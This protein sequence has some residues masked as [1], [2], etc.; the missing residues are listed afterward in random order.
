MPADAAALFPQSQPLPTPLAVPFHV[1]RRER[2]ACY[3]YTSR[4]PV[5]VSAVAEDSRGYSNCGRLHT[6]FGVKV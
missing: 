5:T 6:P 3:E 2:V 1:A 4:K